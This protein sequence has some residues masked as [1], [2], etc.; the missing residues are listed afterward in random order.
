MV[1][2]LVIWLFF[3]NPI[4]TFSPGLRYCAVG[5]YYKSPRY[6]I[7]VVGSTSHFTVLFGERSA[8][9]ES[10][11]DQ[12]LELC[13]RAFQTPEGA[14]ENGF[15]ATTQ[16][17]GVYE[18]LDL[19][20]SKNTNSN[21]NI[22]STEDELLGLLSSSIEVSGAGIILVRC[23]FVN[24]YN[25]LSALNLKIFFAI[26]LQ[27]D[28]FWQATSRLMTGASVD[29]ILQQNF[30]KDRKIIGVDVIDDH[31]IPDLVPG[32]DPVAQ[33][34]IPGTVGGPATVMGP[35]QNP[36][37]QPQQQAMFAGDV[38]HSAPAMTQMELDEEMA[39]RLTREFEEELGGPP[40]LVRSSIARGASPMDVDAAWND[41][42]SGIAAGSSN[43]QSNSHIMSDEELAKKLQAE[44]DAETGGGGGSSVAAVSGDRSDDS[45]PPLMLMDSSA[46]GPQPATP[47]PST[48]TTAN[49][50]DEDEDDAKKPAALPSATD[51]SSLNVGAETGTTQ[52]SV[53]APSATKPDF[54]KYGETF[55]LY[56]YNG[57]RGGVLMPFRVTRLTA[58]EAVGASVALNRSAAAGGHR[59]GPDMSLEDVVR[60]KWPSCMINWLGQN[61]PYID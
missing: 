21:N 57:L 19:Q 22:V 20:L 49:L 61:P 33:P 28:D 59:S 9:Y 6:P 34:P 18:I 23:F 48:A 35:Q 41:G 60:T 11:S 43:S 25:C 42:E 5:D 58:E 1:F 46:Y 56:H 51:A 3:T 45:P 37:S 10:H 8:L 53:A 30:E 14:S 47:P 31:D 13:R 2:A 15:I 16:L 54:E 40:S 29:S 26:P 44:F 17:K 24:S 36:A 38:V 27:W 4:L 52:D 32:D 39:R 50:M 7:W 55:C 12:L